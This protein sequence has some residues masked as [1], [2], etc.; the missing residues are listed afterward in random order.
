MMLFLKHL[1]NCSIIKFLDCSRR[2]SVDFTNSLL[3]ETIYR[4]RKL[5]NSY[6]VKSGMLRFGLL[7]ECC[8]PGIVPDHHLIAAILELVS[9]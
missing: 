6:A 1:L 3:T 8:Q 2:T 4:E 5:V 9:F 7:L